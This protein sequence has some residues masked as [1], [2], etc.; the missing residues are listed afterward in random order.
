M[1]T[2]TFFGTT[3][4]LGKTAKK[5]SI[6]SMNDD[7]NNIIVN[8]SQTQEVTAS[9]KKCCKDF[10]DPGSGIPVKKCW[11]K[12]PGGCPAGCYEE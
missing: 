8:D 11:P 1:Q 7:K 3:Q 10:P 6:E 2:E 9:A 12:P 4:S 5:T